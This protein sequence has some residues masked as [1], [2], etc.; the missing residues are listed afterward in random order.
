M[1]EGGEIGLEKIQMLV[2]A[3][4]VVLRISYLPTVLGRRTDDEEIAFY[5]TVKFANGFIACRLF[6]RH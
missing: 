6:N 2:S 3:Q 5:T 4:N 1:F